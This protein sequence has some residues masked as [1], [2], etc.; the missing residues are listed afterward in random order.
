MKK[1]LF[2]MLPTLLLWLFVSC[3]NGNST[4]NQDEMKFNMYANKEYNYALVLPEG[5]SFDREYV[6]LE[7][8][9]H[10]MS[11]FVWGACEISVEATK[12]YEGMLPIEE[13][14][15]LAKVCDTIYAEDFEANMIDSTSYLIKVHSVNETIYENYL[16]ASYVCR[17]N[18]MNYE[19]EFRY[20]LAKKDRFEKD[21]DEVVKSFKTIE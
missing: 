18:G 21:V 8:G 1:T 7:G 11:L 3:V 20:P 13:S 14:F 12:V 16:R 17:K 5:F 6:D 2:I 4:K 10:A 9:G 19:I 15:N